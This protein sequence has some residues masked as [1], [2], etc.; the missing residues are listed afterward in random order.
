MRGIFFFWGG[1]S[2]ASRNW[3]KITTGPVDIFPGDWNPIGSVVTEILRN[4][5]TD[6]Q[7]D[8][9]TDGWKDGRTDT[10]LLFIID[11]MVILLLHCFPIS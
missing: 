2:H 7:I 11:N 3:L 6:G 8:G 1:V 4:R 5:Q 10:K 9:Q